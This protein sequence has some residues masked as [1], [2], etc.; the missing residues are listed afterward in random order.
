VIGGMPPASRNHRV[1][2][3]GDTPASTAA[4][5]L[6][7]PRA[8]AAQNRCRSSRRPAGGRPGDRIG[9][10]PAAS[11]RRRSCSRIATPQ[12]RGV[13]TTG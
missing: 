4:S 8:I 11:S 12:R 2:T 7:S 6:G 9:S 10:R 3:A 5:S 1:P 13:A